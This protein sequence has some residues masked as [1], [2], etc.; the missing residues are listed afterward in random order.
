MRIL[1]QL[2]DINCFSDVS[3]NVNANVYTAIA[4]MPCS[5]ESG[6]VWVRV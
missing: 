2:V 1:E 5:L 6:N 3:L 4:E